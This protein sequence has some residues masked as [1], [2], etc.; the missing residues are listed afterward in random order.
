MG[1]KKLKCILL[2]NSFTFPSFKLWASIRLED[3]VGISDDVLVGL[4]CEML[5]E[6]RATQTPLDPYTFESLL[7]PFMQGSDFGS[8]EKLAKKFV[9]EL[10]EY[11]SESRDLPGGFGDAN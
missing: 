10:W 2:P 4:I 9:A 5:S 3:Y 7:S 8:G 11:L 6:A 1:S